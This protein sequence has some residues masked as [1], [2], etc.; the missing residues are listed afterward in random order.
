MSEI[1]RFVRW[2]INW[3]RENVPA[4]KMIKTIPD[5]LDD[6]KTLLAESEKSVG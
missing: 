4:D 5:V 3:V 1:E 2:A 6:A